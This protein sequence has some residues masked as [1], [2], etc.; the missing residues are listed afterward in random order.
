VIE[1]YHRPS[2]LEQALDLLDSD[3]AAVLAGGTSLIAGDGPDAVVDLQDLGLDSIALDGD[4]LAVGA[5]TRLRDFATSDLVPQ[6]LRQLAIREAPNTIRNAATIGGTVA[7]GDPESELVAGLLVYE[8]AVT[9][10]GHRGESTTGLADYLSARPH[11][12]ITGVSI[13][14]NGTASA[15]RTGRTP[16]DRPIVLAVAR[17]SE[18]GTILLALTGV[19]SAPV[20]IDAEAISSLDPPAD[21]R[22]S[23][24][25]RRHLAGILSGR[26]I[27][28]LD[29]RP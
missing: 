24:E 6:P 2:T 18:T 3:H 13:A 15:A 26:A 27:A 12:L 14:T 20:L 17:R 25:Y 19:D 9:I 16:A 22:G 28:G 4:R 5:M 11:G 23:A 21:F 10:T 8:S 7:S 29:H 1:S